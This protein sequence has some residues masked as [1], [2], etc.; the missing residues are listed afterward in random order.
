MFMIGMKGVMN[1]SNSGSVFDVSFTIQFRV[2][3]RRSDVQFQKV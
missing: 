3:L 2:L 1:L